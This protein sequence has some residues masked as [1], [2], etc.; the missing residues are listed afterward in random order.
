MIIVLELKTVNSSLHS[1]MIFF[2]CH[3]R[4]FLTDSL[5]SGRNM[6]SDFCCS[7]TVAVYGSDFPS[8]VLPFSTWRVGKWRA[9]CVFPATGPQSEEM[10]R[11]VSRQYCTMSRIH[12]W[13]TWSNVPPGKTLLP[14]LPFSLS[15]NQA[16]PAP[17]CKLLLFKNE[18]CKIILTEYR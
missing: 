14:Q 8:E 16:F 5:L 2:F 3:C 17:V 15:P 1:W 18:I 13:Q 9:F 4:F 12:S 11:D 10:M 6:S 7:A